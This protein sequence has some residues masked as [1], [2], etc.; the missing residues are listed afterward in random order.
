M[1][2]IV[3]QHI[4]QYRIFPSNRGIKLSLWEPSRSN[5]Y[6]P[7]PYSFMANYQLKSRAEAREV[8]QQY[9]KMSGAGLIEADDLPMHGRIKVMPYPTWSMAPRYTVVEAIAAGA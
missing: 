2:R 4:I 3:S 9:L 1:L 7:Q 5:E 6:R 8:L